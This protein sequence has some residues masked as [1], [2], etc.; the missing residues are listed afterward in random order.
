MKMNTLTFKKDGYEYIIKERKSNRI[1]MY[2]VVAETEEE[3]HKLFR[4]NSH[5]VKFVGSVVWN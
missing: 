5:L 3:A 2:R 1:T 4:S